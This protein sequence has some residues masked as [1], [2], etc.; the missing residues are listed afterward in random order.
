M[1]CVGAVIVSFDLQQRLL[2]DPRRHVFLSK[3]LFKLTS[4][5]KLVDSACKMR[6]G[7]R[8]TELGSDLLAEE[9]C[10]ICSWEEERHMMS[11]RGLRGG[12]R[13]LKRISDVV[14]V[15]VVKCQNSDESYRGL[16]QYQNK[17]IVT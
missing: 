6:V 17:V 3:I 7:G 12:G 14:V 1:A 2:T 8:L 5:S 15:V 13:A 10:R 11:G 4:I 16:I 9:P